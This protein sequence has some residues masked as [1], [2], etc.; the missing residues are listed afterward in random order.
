MQIAPRLV[1]ESVVIA[2]SDTGYDISTEHLPHVFEQF[3]TTRSQT[4][5]GSGLGLYICKLTVDE[6][7]GSLAVKSELARGQASPSIY[8]CRPN[9]TI[10]SIKFD[11]SITSSIEETYVG[12]ANRHCE[13]ACLQVQC[14]KRRERRL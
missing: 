2:V 14:H 5:H 12:N 4:S 1:G 10:F 9:P 7:G 13:V 8:H 11:V 3:Y 6:L